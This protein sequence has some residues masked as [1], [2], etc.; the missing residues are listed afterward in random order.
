MKAF[1][2]ILSV[3]S[4]LW[5]RNHCLFVHLQMGTISF[6]IRMSFCFKSTKLQVCFWAFQTFKMIITSKQK[7]TVKN[8][9]AI[10]YNIIIFSLASCPKFYADWVNSWL[11]SYSEFSDLCRNQVHAWCNIILS[12]SYATK[13]PWITEQLLIC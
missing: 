4:H 2:R 3:C 6:L 10:L 8:H 7:A 13:K 12:T 1:E 5:Q 11:R 9:L